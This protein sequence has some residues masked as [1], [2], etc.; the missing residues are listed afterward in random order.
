VS[1]FVIK[2]CRYFCW[3]VLLLSPSVLAERFCFSFAESYY[4]QLYCQVKAAGKGKNL[5]ELYEFSRND[6][7]VQ[8]LLLKRPAADIGVKLLMPAM[9]SV[10]KPV[11]RVEPVVSAPGLS[12]CRRD[13]NRFVCAGRA[14][15]LVG[16][17]SNDR[18]PKEALSA[19]NRMQLADYQGSRADGDQLDRYLQSSYRHYLLKMIDIGLGGATLS[20][21]KFAYLFEDLSSKGLGFS[22]RFETMYRYLKKDK[23]AMAVP[24]KSQVPAGLVVDDCYL[25]EPL[26]VCRSGG[27]NWLF[28]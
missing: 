5:P 7:M 6:E 18:L 9:T 23:R 28:R 12:Q 11:M 2:K 17:R 24:A 19:A 14:F 27:H 10:S 26:L 4:Q 16:N 8:A 20:Y 22:E 25:L 1:V 21:G 13:G 15:Q 3:V